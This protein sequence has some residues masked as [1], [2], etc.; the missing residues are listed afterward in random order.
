MTPDVRQLLRRIRRLERLVEPEP[1]P[2][3]HGEPSHLVATRSQAGGVL[4][5][6]VIDAL[7]AA[8]TDR[9]YGTPRDWSPPVSPRGWGPT[10]STASLIAAQESARRRH[11]TAAQ[12]IRVR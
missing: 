8:G 1:E 2:E 4:N 6:D 3:P 5:Q 11:P 10:S 7:N 12:E 9:P